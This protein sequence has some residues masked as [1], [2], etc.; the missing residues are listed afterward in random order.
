[1]ATLTRTLVCFS[2]AGAS[3]SITPVKLDAAA[4]FSSCDHEMHVKNSEASRNIRL[5]TNNHHLRGLDECRG[6]V[7]LLQTH[8]GDGISGDDT[9]DHLSGDRQ[10]Y[11][12]HQAVHF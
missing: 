4:T 11:L 3:F 1:M 10:P 7:A 12:G 2:K 9:G 6:N 8:L 5:R